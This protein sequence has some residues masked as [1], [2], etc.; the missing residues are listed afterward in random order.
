MLRRLIALMFILAVTGGALAAA[1][2]RACDHESGAEGMDTMEC[3]RKA[4]AR[5]DAHGAV[6]S[7]LCC[8]GCAQSAPATAGESEAVRVAQS[9]ASGQLPAAP[10]PRDSA[11]RAAAG[12][13]TFHPIPLAS[14]PAYILHLAL[15]I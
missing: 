4:R 3:C 15:L 10:P 12:I 7:E 6:P 9:Y 13:H 8:S 1:P 11:P 5:K 2:L 14:K